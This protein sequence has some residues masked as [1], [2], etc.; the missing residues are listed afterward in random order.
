MSDTFLS[1]AYSFPYIFPYN[2]FL[3]IC[4]TCLVNLFMLVKLSVSY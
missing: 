1:I 2:Q 4:S 3:F